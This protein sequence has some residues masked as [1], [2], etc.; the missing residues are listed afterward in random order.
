MDSTDK[1]HSTIVMFKDVSLSSD[2]PV[3][4]SFYV[5]SSEKI[6]LS[7]RIK[8]RLH[9]GE[10]IHRSLNEVFLAKNPTLGMV[11]GI[12]QVPNFSLKNK[13]FVLY[14]RH[15]NSQNL[16]G[17]DQPLKHQAFENRRTYVHENHWAVGNEDSAL[18]GSYTVPLIQDPHE[19]NTLKKAQKLCQG[20]QF[21]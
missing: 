14:I 2:I 10:D 5:T 7:C 4:K 21:S 3:L 16:H 17:R 15:N 6:C 18:K 9:K 11:R 1:R 8:T 19:S 20:D 12:S 13:K